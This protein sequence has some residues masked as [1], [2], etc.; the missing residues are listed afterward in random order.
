MFKLI[1]KYYYLYIHKTTI[2]NKSI[3]RID[4]QANYVM[5]FIDAHYLLLT[6]HL[7]VT[8]NLICEIDGT[9][10]IHSNL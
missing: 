10:S 2:L 5:L 7:N 1:L 9:I 3:K 8:K 4:R 6:L